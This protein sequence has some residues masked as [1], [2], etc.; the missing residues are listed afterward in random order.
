MIARRLSEEWLHLG[1]GASAEVEPPFD[2]LE[3][4]AAYEQRHAADG[5]EGRLV[6]QYRFTQSW[7]LWEMHPAGAEV[8]IC[9]S[10]TMTLV[11]EVDGDTVRT[12]LNSGD[13]AINPF[14]TWHTADIE[15]EA[16][17]IFITSGLGTQHRPR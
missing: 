13:Y 3:W 12:T 8:V 11:Q 7:D 2:G 9:T 17:A 6:S 5:A 4:Y 10:G 1:L 15:A 14:G 16:E